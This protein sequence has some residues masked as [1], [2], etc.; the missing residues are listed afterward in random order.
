VFIAVALGLPWGGVVPTAQAQTITVTSADPPAGEQG[1]IN[2][3]VLI[4]GKGFKNGAKAKFYRTGTGD[5]DGINVKSTRYVSS[6]QLQATIDIADWAT[7]SLFDIEVQNADGRTGKGTELFSV[8]AKKVDP[9]AV[10]AP[11]PTP[12]EHISGVPGYPGYLDSTFGDGTGKMIGPR[13]MEIRAIAI[14][15][16]G[17]EERLVAVGDSYSQCATSTRVWKLARYLPAGG[18]DPSFGSGGVVTTGFSRT[19]GWIH[20]VAVDEDEK[21]LVVGYVQGQKTGNVGVVA[22]YNVDGSLDTS[23]GGTGI[24]YLPYQKYLTCARAVTLQSDGKIVLTGVAG[25]VTWVV[26][27][28]TD[29]TL[30]STFNGTGMFFYTAAQSD[31]YGIVLQR[32]T[33]GAGTEERIVVSGFGYNPADN[34][35][36]GAV[37]RLTSAG[38]LDPTFNGA[39]VVFTTFDDLPTDFNSVALDSLNRIVASGYRYSST[40]PSQV[41]LARYDVSGALDGTFGSGGKIVVES[42]LK[43]SGR[44]VAIQEDDSIVVAGN[45]NGVTPNLPSLWRFTPTGAPDQTFGINGWVSD[46]IASVS[47]NVVCQG[48]ALQTD[49]RIIL[50]GWLSVDGQGVVKEGFIARFWQ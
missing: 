50:A 21:I 34:A 36:S 7:L 18:P 20:G 3:N 2:L 19:P 5:P 17:G 35:R 14:Q 32:I 39:G 11:T 38:V 29:G 24:V 10:P 26:R 30:D 47:G 15:S 44:G 45:V 49:G 25:W 28:N 1:T 6:T 12:S 33:T 4:K 43:S 8:T 27:L 23:F 46:P 42:G 48:L 31:G 16:V 13:Y 41:A 37:W 40:S 9:C 22:R